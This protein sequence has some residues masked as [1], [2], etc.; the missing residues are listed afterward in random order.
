[1]PG[2][3]KFISAASI[4]GKNSFSSTAEEVSCFRNELP[5][6]YLLVLSCVLWSVAVCWNTAGMPLAPLSP[7]LS[8]SHGT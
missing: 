7:S 2:V 5:G 8:R 4:P 3:V 6:R 1:M